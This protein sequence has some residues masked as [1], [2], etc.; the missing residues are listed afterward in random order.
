MVIKKT[1]WEDVITKCPHC[2][3]RIRVYVRDEIEVT[4][5]SGYITKERKPI[6]KKK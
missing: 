6:K 2:K 5:H 4:K 3:L 1:N